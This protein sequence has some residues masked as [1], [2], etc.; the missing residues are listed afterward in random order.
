MAVQEVLDEA[1]S[2][3][4]ELRVFSQ[5]DTFVDSVMAGAPDLE[6]DRA[7]REGLDA[8]ISVPDRLERFLEILATR[9]GRFRVKRDTCVTNCHPSSDLGRNLFPC[10][11]FL[12]YPIQQVRSDSGRCYLPKGSS[13]HHLGPGLGAVRR[14]QLLNPA[15][16]RPSKCIIIIYPAPAD[17]SNHGNVFRSLREVQGC[18]FHG[19]NHFGAPRKR[20]IG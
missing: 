7:S 13:L 14:V 15:G 16:A 18:D 3:L 8:A 11:V 19:T 17:E 20:R 5:G 12:P 2:L 1:V 10:G 9:C 6:L 4:D